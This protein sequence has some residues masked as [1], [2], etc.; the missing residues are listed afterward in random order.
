MFDVNFV[1][2]NMT[3]EELRDGMYWLAERLYADSCLIKRRQSFFDAFWRERVDAVSA[4][5]G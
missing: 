5:G 2:A 1:P 4:I 3:V